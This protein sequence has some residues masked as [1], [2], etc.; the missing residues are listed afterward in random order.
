[1]HALVL[2]LAAAAGV[3]D[4]S[5]QATLR[6]QRAPSPISIDGSLDEQAWQEADLAR[7]FR[8]VEPAE[9]EPAT[10]RTEVRVLYD[11]GAVYVGA[12]LY[13]TEPA[14]IVKRLSRRDNSADADRFTFYLDA[15]HDHLTGALFEV[16]AGGSQRDAIISNDTNQDSSWD[17]VW[18]SAVSVDRDGWTVEIRIPLSQL[19]FLKGQQQTWGF[20]VSRF[21]YRKNETDWFELVPRKENGLASRMAHLTD[22]DGIEPRRTLE[23]TPYSVARSEFVGTR[24]S[25]NPFND[26]ARYFAAT[27]FDLKYALRPNVV[28]NAAVNPD[29]GQVEIDPA[30]VNLGAF[31]TFFPEKRPFFIEGAKIF[32]NFGS[33]GANSRNGFNRDEPVLIHARRI[34]RAPQGSASGDFVDVPSG[35]SILGAAK[36][37]GKT[38]HGWSFG[39][40][41]AVTARE[42]AKVSNVG[43]VSK[44]EVEP[45]TNYF[46]GRLLKEFTGGRSG[47]GALFT[48]VNR[49]LR[50][51]SLKNLL[52]GRANIAGVD[53]YYFLDADREWVVNGRMVVSDV[54]GTAAAIER[55]QLE[56]QRY[57]QRPDT[58]EVTFDPQRTSL[59]GWNGDVNL[60]RQRGGVTVNAAL[61]GVSP[62]WES[63]DLGFH[64]N[65]DV[66]GNHV[67]VNWRQLKPDRVTRDRNIMVAK[68]YVWDY[69]NAKLADG[70]MAFPNTTF[71]NYW[72]VGGSVAFFGGAQDD[73]LT[74]GGPPARQLPIGFANLYLNTDYR[75]RIVLQVNGGTE[76]RD[77]GGGN[78]DGSFSVEWKPSS[79]VNLSSGPAYSHNINVAQ[80][81]TT[82]DD[83]SA[84]A[85]F[86]RRYVF[87]RLEQSQL[88][89]ETRVNVL[90]G[91]KT[92]LQ[93]YM[94]PLVVVGRYLDFRSLARP[95]TFTFDPYLSTLPLDPDFNFKSLRIN[96]IFRW[97]WRLGSTL[98]I[99]WTQQRQDLANPGQFQARRD[100]GRVFTA[101]GDD[102]LMAKI[103]YWFNR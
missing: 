32:D 90:F 47:L 45:P 94:Q 38:T 13:D 66:W 77:G 26:G 4:A 23:I 97:E 7:N 43:V 30:V 1:M 15:M 12:R 18:E 76:W 9:G 35:A 69:A 85:T 28:L 50:D 79:Q 95:R 51:A 14:K 52:P 37:T 5:A 64:F 33:L 98:Y 86:G 87:G 62:G 70:F 41:E 91:P 89:V 56:P 99:A 78:A 2:L 24:T 17:A 22:I 40:L 63:G 21:I 81:V 84:T 60:N 3:Q 31:E 27:G 54:A 8:Q 49:D 67:S 102:I 19:R 96:A 93:V 68:F 80:Y 25:G 55:L 42:F 34:G 100:L 48:S 58:P 72:E 73:R 103:T 57:F 65:G 82:V 11:N 75:R 29:F 59:H 53:G 16:S 20:N 61:W 92:S 74:R 101:P 6:A 83:P 46:A 88:S 10:E 71:H 36:M 44:T 39:V